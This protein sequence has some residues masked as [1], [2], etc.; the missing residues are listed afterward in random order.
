MKDCHYDEYRCED[1]QRDLALQNLFKL[2][3]VLVSL[4]IMKI[5][6][7]V[8]EECDHCKY[9]IFEV[10]E[11][12]CALK[13]HDDHCNHTD[14]FDSQVDLSYIIKKLDHREEVVDHEVSHPRIENRKGDMDCNEF[15]AA[16]VISSII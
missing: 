5:H 16:H 13:D 12:N 4:I 11:I 2:A 14:C 10:C 7:N 9:H 6:P 15:F 8:A 3:K 1:Y